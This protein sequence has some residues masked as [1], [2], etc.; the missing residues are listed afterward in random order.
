MMEIVKVFTSDKTRDRFTRG[1]HRFGLSSVLLLI[2]LPS[3][4]FAQ[5]HL[6]KYKSFRAFDTGHSGGDHI[7]D[8]RRDGSGLGMPDRLGDY[9][10][11]S[12][13]VI[14]EPSTYD[15]GGRLFWV[16]Q[17][18]C[19]ILVYG[20]QQAFSLGD[21]VSLSG[22]LRMTDGN[23]FS[24][25]TGLATLGDLAIE[26][27]KVRLIGSSHTPLPAT[28]TARDFSMTPERYGGNLIRVSELVT[29]GRSLRLDGDTFAWLHGAEDSVLLYID[30]DTHCS[31]R[32]ES[33]AITSLTGIVVRMSTPGCLASS[34]EWCIAPRAEEDMVFSSAGSSVA[35]VT[36]GDLKMSL[37]TQE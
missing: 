7:C 35:G 19:G 15:D 16:R 34:P 14:A 32:P 5:A 33:Q 23:Y 10:T 21:S 17:A 27:A 20:E 6:W 25:E 36:W 3:I 12:G 2:L 9:V 24:S 30:A 37:T 4:S 18:S 28:T 8:L 29:V 31:L 13:S 22:W 26:S 11:I 1:M